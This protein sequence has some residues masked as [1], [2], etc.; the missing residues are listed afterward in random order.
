M[1]TCSNNH[2]ALAAMTVSH[3]LM[4]VHEDAWKGFGDHTL[5]HAVVYLGMEHPTNELQQW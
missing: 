3:M 5:V 2:A 1:L 4:G